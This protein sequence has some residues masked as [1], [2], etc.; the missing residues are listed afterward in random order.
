MSCNIVDMVW[1]AITSSRFDLI[2]F[3]IGLMGYIILHNSRCKHTD[4]ELHKKLD[5]TFEVNANV[6]DNVEE[7]AS[8]MHDGDSTPVDSVQFVHLLKRMKCDDDADQ[9]TAE[10]DA[11]LES[12][13][14]HP[15][16]FS[17]V[18]TI[19]NYCSRSEKADLALAD[20]LLE[21][22][23]PAEEWDVL[24]SFICFYLENEMAEKA[25]NVFELNYAT[26]FDIE[27]DEDMEWRL[28]M[29]ALQ[30]GRKS[31]AEHLCQTSQSEVAKHVSTIQQWWKR[32]AVKMGEARVENM[33][34][35]LTRLSNMFNERYPFE[36][37][38]D[39]E[40]TCFLGDES[41]C[42]ESTDADSDWEAVQ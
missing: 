42:E 40:S 24:N 37:H 26:F 15:F 12:N 3:I 9:V 20:R 5:M 19:L 2:M 23:Q 28:L 32:T 34:D 25:C 1:E 16:T 31:L 35:V 18:Q 39:D 22:M 41:G 14:S 6:N 29:A 10:M 7:D 4:K 33:G 13:P 8:S 11:F 30:C 36:E 21:C 17:E 27:L 38:S